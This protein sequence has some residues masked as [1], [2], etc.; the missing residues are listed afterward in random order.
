MV[1]IADNNKREIHQ[2]LCN[3]LGFDVLQT[4]TVGVL[5]EQQRLI[6]GFSYYQ[7][8]KICQ[9]TACADTP[10][11][12]TPET[13]SELLRIPFDLLKCKIAKFETSNKNVKANRFCKGIGCVK[14]GVLRY[15]HHDGTHQVVW[16][17]TKQE[18]SKKGW[19]RYGKQ[20]TLV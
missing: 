10:R 8:G 20:K 18:I 19:Y 1:I 13:L 15:A 7:N 4:V 9:I 6:A 11:W 2:W 16:S 3:K 12:C 17:L 5:N 14:E